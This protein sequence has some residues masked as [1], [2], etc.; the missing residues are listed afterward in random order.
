[1][2]CGGVYPLAHHFA[3]PML[4]RSNPAH[5]CWVC[6]QVDPPPT[7]FCDE[8]DTYLHGGKCLAAFLASEE[9]QLVIEH[10]HDVLQSEAAYEQIHELLGK[11]QLLVNFL[12]RQALLEDGVFTFPD[13]DIWPA[14]RT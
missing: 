3:G 14:D 10:G 5:G 11:V 2:P 4:D 12:H 9:G 13:G 7:L 8:W 1:M 6:G